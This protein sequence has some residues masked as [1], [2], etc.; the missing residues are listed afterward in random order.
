MELRSGRVRSYSRVVEAAAKSDARFAKS[1][2]VKELCGRIPQRR[3]WGERDTNVSHSLMSTA[4]LFPLSIFAGVVDSTAANVF[5][6]VE[7]LALVRDQVARVRI[8]GCEPRG[9]EFGVV[10]EPG[11]EYSMKLKVLGVARGV[12]SVF[13]RWGIADACDK[14]L[15]CVNEQCYGPGS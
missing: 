3:S 12:G 2:N 8:E 7:E 15:R 5:W 14:C 11:T 9:G 13:A 1:E 10:V 6:K 4:F